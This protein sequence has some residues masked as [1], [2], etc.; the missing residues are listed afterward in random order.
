MIHHNLLLP[1]NDFPFEENTDDLARTPKQKRKSTRPSVLSTPSPAPETS[2]D[3]ETEN[4][5]TFTAVPTSGDL[6]LR[7]Q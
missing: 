3:E 2:S 6:W 4:M 1:C 7:N 5:L